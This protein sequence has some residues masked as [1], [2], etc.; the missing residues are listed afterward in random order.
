MGEHGRG[1][2]SCPTP[3]PRAG[4]HSAQPMMAPARQNIRHLLPPRHRRHSARP[5]RGWALFRRVWG[6]CVSQARKNPAEQRSAGFSLRNVVNVWWVFGGAAS[7]KLWLESHDSKGLGSFRKK[8][9]PRGCLAA[10]AAPLFSS[11]IRISHQKHCY[12]TR[13]GDALIFHTIDLASHD[14]LQIE[15]WAP[16][17]AIVVEEFLCCRCGSG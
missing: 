1:D 16:R 6:G 2:A 12:S 3:A 15:C 13:G 7:L 8:S 9:C 4:R 11:R 17:P 14:A 10:P 5:V